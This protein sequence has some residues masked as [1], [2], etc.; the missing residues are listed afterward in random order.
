MGNGSTT[1]N[2]LTPPTEL[3]SR[4][5]EVAVNQLN[6]LEVSCDPHEDKSSMWFQGSVNSTDMLPAPPPIRK[7]TW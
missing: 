7:G 6:T 4:K 1:S 2:P 5:A 3:T